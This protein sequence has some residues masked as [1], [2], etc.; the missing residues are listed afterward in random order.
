MK[1]II[2]LPTRENSI[3]PTELYFEDEENQISD[4][5][6]YQVLQDFIPIQ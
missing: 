1:P 3:Q 6:I 4:I 2:R 5:E